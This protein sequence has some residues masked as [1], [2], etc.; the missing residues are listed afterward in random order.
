[1]LI[2]VG[3]GTGTAAGDAALHA[4]AASLAG[5]GAFARVKAAVLNGE[6]TLSDA[7]EGAENEPV[8]LLPFMMSDGVTFRRRLLQAMLHIPGARTPLLYPP[9]GLNPGLAD[10]IVKRAEDM[11]ETASWPLP[12]CR[13]LLIA[14][15]SLQDPASA[16]AAES[17][18]ER[19]AAWH[20]FAGVETAFLDQPPRLDDVLA[21]DGAP[22]L[23]V[24]LFAGEGRHG[25]EDME[26]AFS[27]AAC[28][29]RYCGAIGSDG[30]LA[31]LAVGHL[32]SMPY[33]TEWAG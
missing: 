15:G 13:L 26:R 31:A 5:Q 24:G 9:L 29:A 18:Q 25:A 1:V 27:R 20:R 32:K 33:S 11:S 23:G 4:L 30:G 14:H 22:L 3:H 12:E 17:H 19:I 10:L 21:R 6:P 16:Q 28:P 7:L 2:V 8:H